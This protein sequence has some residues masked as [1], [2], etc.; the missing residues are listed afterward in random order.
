MKKFPDILK[1]VKSSREL[2]LILNIGKDLAWFEG[3]FPAMAILP[4]MVAVFW[5]EE[6]LR[7]YFA[8]NAAIKSVDNVRFMHPIF[9]DSVVELD[10]AISPETKT[11]HFK[12]C[13]P[14]SPDIWIYSSGVLR[15]V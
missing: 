14:D 15:V 13:D 10:I 6:Y 11:L 7:I 1:T 4:G 2:K 3:H 5:T 9:P 12:F 8:P